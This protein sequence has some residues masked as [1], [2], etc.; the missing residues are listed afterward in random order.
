METYDMHPFGRDHPGALLDFRWTERTPCR[1][2]HTEV[3]DLPLLLRDW[4]RLK[5][6][7]GWVR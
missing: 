1:P 2:Q 3:S 7:D 4:P 5:G 6:E